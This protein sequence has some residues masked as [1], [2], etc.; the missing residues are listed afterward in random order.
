MDYH[1]LSAFLAKLLEA[2]PAGK[3]GVPKPCDPAGVL[4]DPTKKKL[5][6][7]YQWIEELEVW[8]STK[9]RQV[10]PCAYVDREPAEKIQAK[11]DEYMEHIRKQ[12]GLWIPHDPE[13]I[14]WD[15][16]RQR[17]REQRLH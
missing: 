14:N 9:T 12:P 3:G 17:L 6:E 13:S 8:A 2:C 4:Q 11:I 15:L 5:L 1:A 16:V 10:L 7:S